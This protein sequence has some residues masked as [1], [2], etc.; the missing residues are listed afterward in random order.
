MVDPLTEEDMRA[1]AA[2]SS[3][4]DEWEYV[5]EDQLEPGDVWEYVDERDEAEHA[6]ADSD[7]D[8]W[9]YVTEDQLEPGDVWEYVDEKDD[10]NPFAYKKVQGHTDELNSLY[11]DGAHIAAELKDTF[12][13]IKDVLTFKDVFKK[14]EK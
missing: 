6:S 14:P 11:R 2:E 9:E 8:E 7:E 5:T 3:D 12:D 1:Q 13:E 4:E 10:P